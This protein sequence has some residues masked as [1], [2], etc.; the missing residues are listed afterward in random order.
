MKWNGDFIDLKACLLR[1]GQ[2]NKNRRREKL[3]LMFNN[4]ADVAT[5]MWWITLNIYLRLRRMLNSPSLKITCECHVPEAPFSS[6]ATAYSVCC[7]HSPKS[8]WSLYLMYTAKIPLPAGKKK[9]EC[10]V[11]KG[12]HLE[13]WYS[14]GLLWLCQ[15]MKEFVQNFQHQ[16]SWEQRNFLPLWCLP[17]PM[18]MS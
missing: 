8:V 3:R 2:K 5:K 12:S 16:N 4:N 15:S 18:L 1:T 14:C 9:N 13:L 10:N 7:V 6:R 11:I 17:G